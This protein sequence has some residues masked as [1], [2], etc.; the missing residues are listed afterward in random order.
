[1]RRLV[2]LIILLLL[3]PLFSVTAS[4]DKGEEYIESFWD[5]LPSGLSDSLISEKNP[6]DAVGVEALFRHIL[7]SLSEEQSEI[8]AFFA[9][10]VGI[11]IMSAVASFCP[12]SFADSAGRVISI[13][14]AVVIYERI[15]SLYG[16]ISRSVSEI[17]AFF[18]ALIPITSAVSAMSGAT[19]TANTHAS[20]MYLIL[21]L[22]SGG[23]GEI[24][25][26]L[27]AFSLALALAGSV[28]G[29]S[30]TR[31]CR[32]F[33]SFF[34]WTVGIMSAIISGILSLQTVIS[35]ATDS[36]ALRTARYMTTSLVPVVGSTVSSAIS[37]LAG[38]LSYARSIIGGGA[39]SA[40]LLL[41]VS[42]LVMLLLYRLALSLCVTISDFF[43]VG[44]G[45]FSSFR[46]S[47]D[48]VTALYALMAISF[49]LQ[50]ILFIKVGVL[51]V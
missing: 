17:S 49:V 10:L 37:T 23:G 48:S 32:G 44:G 46:F 51:L 35:S 8:S 29:E 31:I 3:L 13:V 7:S 24:I 43:G 26:I 5:S 11:F 36:A 45:L 38:G 25:S 9:S 6:I 16:I 28:G 15:Y 19:L 1:M 18:T 4:A 33:R 47:L 12:S 41:S 22:F 39:I 40:I 42:P 30:V 21:T 27:C 34:G 14:G 20:G 2:M 50:L